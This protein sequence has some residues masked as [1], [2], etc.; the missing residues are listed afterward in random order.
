M[1][2]S[3]TFCRI[4]FGVFTLRKCSSIFISA[5]TSTFGRFQFS[6]EKA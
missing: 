2:W 1:A 5:F 4:S 6:T 3:R